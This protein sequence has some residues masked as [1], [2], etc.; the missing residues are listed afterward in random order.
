MINNGGYPGTG[1]LADW[2]AAHNNQVDMTI[3]VDKSKRPSGS[4]LPYYYG[5]H[6]PIIDGYCQ[7]PM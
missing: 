6:K 1:I 7:L 4:R 3:E 5:I 2:A